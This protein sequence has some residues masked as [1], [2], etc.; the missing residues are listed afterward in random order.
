MSVRIFKLDPGKTV[1]EAAQHI[2][3]ALAETE[4]MD[5]Q[6]FS[7]ENGEYVVQAIDVCG[8]IGSL[9]GMK[10]AISVR[11]SGAGEEHIIV[12]TG[13]GR[14]AD[15]RLLIAL[16]VVIW[17][18]MIPAAAAVYRQHR[19]TGAVRRAAQEYLETK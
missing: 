4:K 12:D 16:S 9:L 11:V 13:R 15:K 19:L 10:R 14:W 3:R 2:R 5:V 8:R 6:V 1:A 18:L 7:F 17:P